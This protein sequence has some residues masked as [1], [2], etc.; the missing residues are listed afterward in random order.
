MGVIKMKSRNNQLMVKLISLMFVV[1]LTACGGGGGGG[2]NTNSLSPKNELYFKDGNEQLQQT[3]VQTI[4]VQSIPLDQETYIGYIAG[5]EI[6]LVRSELGDLIFLLPIGISAGDHTITVKINGKEYQKKIKVLESQT[7]SRSE[8]LDVLNAN[9]ELAQ[10]TLIETLERQRAT[11]GDQ[12]IIDDLERNINLLNQKE[13]HLSS[14]TDMELD[15]LAKIFTSLEMGSATIMARS[16]SDVQCE[17]SMAAY[18]AKVTVAVAAVGLSVALSP[19]IVGGIGAAIIAGLTVHHVI[20]DV[21]QGFLSLWHNCVAARFNELIEEAFP[22]SRISSNL[23]SRTTVVNDSNIYLELNSGTETFYKVKTEYNATQEL[24]DFLP[25]VKSLVNRFSSIVPN[26]ILTFINNAQQSYKEVVNPNQLSITDINNPNVSGVLKMIDA[27]V[28]SLKF[29]A[30]VPASQ[31]EN[32]SF[33]IYDAKND[34]K[35]IYRVDLSVPAV[36]PS[37]SEENSIVVSNGQKCKVVDILK[38]TQLVRYREYENRLLVTD[39]RYQPG[40]TQNLKFTKLQDADV[41]IGDI[42]VAELESAEYFYLK[43]NVDSTW[44]TLP[45][46]SLHKD[47]DGNIQ[48]IKEYSPPRQ[49]SLNEWGVVLKEDSYCQVRLA[50]YHRNTSHCYYS[51]PLQTLDGNWISVFERVRAFFDSSY[52]STYE[53]YYYSQPQQG[54]NGSWQVAISKIDSYYVD[55]RSYYKTYYSTPIF[56]NSGKLV[57]VKSEHIQYHDNEVVSYHEYFSQPLLNHILGR[58]ESVSKSTTQY[59]SDGGVQ[60]KTISHEPKQNL[61]GDWVAL[62]SKSQGYDEVPVERFY[63]EPLLNPNGNWTVAEIATYIGGNLYQS[64]TPTR[65]SSSH[66]WECH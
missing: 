27:E 13:I 63:S 37:I 11:D 66:N 57:S 46:K 54:V 44:M 41:D 47:I 43:Q 26:S 64:C 24:M 52:Y 25:V 19:T 36:C 53:D 45:Y 59:F 55:G 50:S 42:W 51:E 62:P 5:E 34:I 10:N 35:T 38:D 33:A 60:Y 16:S 6:K 8:S 1:L 17:S 23:F 4:S 14:A 49:N 31:L 3:G 12:K 18:A 30:L 58:W 21:G 56:E 20:D 2:E 32:F 7:F 39:E 48:L 29:R 28:F 15:Y 61:S 65:L 40:N 9:I 22:S